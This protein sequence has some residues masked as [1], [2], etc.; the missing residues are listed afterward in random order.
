MTRRVNILRLRLRSLFR[1][2]RVERELDKELAFHLARQ[3]EENIARGIPPQ[4]AR[5]AAQRALGGVAQIQ[6]ECRDMR[7][8]NFIETL[9]SD[10]RYAIRSLRRTPAF[11]AIVVL[12]L[13]LS[14]GA[15]RCV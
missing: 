6:E 7:R 10:L 11:T 4:E 14:I 1:R 8:T 3:V 9:A 15:N 13:A 5:D 12:T 2:G